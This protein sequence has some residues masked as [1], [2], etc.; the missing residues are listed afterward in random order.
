MERSNSTARSSS[1]LRRPR[2]EP[3]PMRHRAMAAFPVTFGHRRIIPPGPSH[4][5]NRGPGPDQPLPQRSPQFNLLGNVRDL[6]NRGGHPGHDQGRRLSIP[7]VVAPQI[8]VV[9][10]SFIAFSTLHHPRCVAATGQA[11]RSR[12][13]TKTTSAD[14][15]GHRHLVKDTRAR[16]RQTRQT[17]AKNHELHQKVFAPAVQA[18]SE[19]RGHGVLWLH[20]VPTSSGAAC[21]FFPI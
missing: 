12:H 1:S 9:S 19:R 21:P 6:E 16:S 3:H 17:S 5:A 15:V 4:R 8:H 18:L 13:A 10:T 2:L 7:Q 20:G 11:S 14:S